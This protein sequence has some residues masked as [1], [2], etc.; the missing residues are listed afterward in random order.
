MEQRTNNI[1]ETE[2]NMAVKSRT[3]GRGFKAPAFGC[4]AAPI[5]GTEH[6]PLGAGCS[7]CLLISSALLIYGESADPL[8]NGCSL[9][10]QYFHSSSSSAN[11]KKQKDA[12]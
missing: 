6:P 2:R 8:H 1:Y 3:D 10:I 11:S 7:L 5:Q 4:Q 9:L 12:A